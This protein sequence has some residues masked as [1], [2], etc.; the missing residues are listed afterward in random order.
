M[1]GISIPGKI[2]VK[3]FKSTEGFFLLDSVISLLVVSV[4]I[5]EILVFALNAGSLSVKTNVKI[6]ESIETRNRSAV[7]LFK[8]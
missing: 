1:T 5:I 2:K 7:E 4:I 6:V 3:G 8:D